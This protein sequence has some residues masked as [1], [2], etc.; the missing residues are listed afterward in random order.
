MCSIYRT[1]FCRKNDRQ[2]EI[3]PI[4]NE[5]ARRLNETSEPTRYAAPAVDRAIRI[6]RFLKDRN[7]AGVS[8]IA[9]AL[10]ITRS[11]C[12]AIL[13]TM[14]RQDFVTFD[15]SAK[16]YGLGP[17]LLEF[18]QQASA[19]GVM[20]D[21]VRPHLRAFVRDTGMSIFLIERISYTRLLVVEREETEDDVRV[22]LAIGTRIPI[23]HSAS[24]RAALAFLP[25]REIADLIHAAPVE[26]MTPHTIVD[27]AAIV[28]ALD[29]VRNS[30]YAVG[31]G[32]NMLGVN[33]VAAPVFDR[34][35]ALK[36][37]VSTLGPAPVLENDRLEILGQALADTGAFITAAIG[38]ARPVA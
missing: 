31:F 5:G 28:A 32:E 20:R 35:G 1:S 4:V 21:A 13:K 2:S 7:S 18:T 15:D 22:S 33:S 12:F 36:Y 6:L 24:G 29:V 37:V 9:K 25:E 10:D 26:R 14:Q 30:G 16:R 17:A 8:E 23:T 19:E 3:Q 11:N 27:A 34:T 38:G